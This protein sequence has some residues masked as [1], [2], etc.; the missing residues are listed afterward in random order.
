M[1]L[2]IG[3]DLG[4]TKIIA[5]LVKDGQ[6]IRKF[7]CNTHAEL[8]KKAVLY[9]L[10]LAMDF[11]YDKKVE[12]IG[13]GVAGVVNDGKVVFS[14]NL[15]LTG[16]DLAKILKKKYKVPVSVENDAHCFTVGEAL[17]GA[18]KDFGVVVGV[19]LGTGIGSGIVMDNLLYNGKS[20]AI[21]LG[22]TTINFDGPKASS[23]IKGT[24]EGYCGGYY[25][26]KNF[27]KSAK[28]LYDD[29]RL[30]KKAALKKWEKYG[31][32]LAVG[33]A[34]IV[35]T[36]DP[37]IVVVGGSIANAWKF[38]YK[39]MNKEIKKRA[40]TKVIIKKRE[41]ENSTV[42]GAALI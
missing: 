34:N 38:F 35:N 12:S 18:G 22:H 24:L 26:K 7:K 2:S 20:G 17:F 33:I 6:A 36:L 15:K 32:L 29:A 14:P 27:G 23:G 5:A 30:G 3:V 11:V 21:E 42:I 1:A 37:E 39:S 28:D 8:G 9:N 40:V 31:Q 19:T 13:I 10:F 16:A 25:F 4:G 41:L